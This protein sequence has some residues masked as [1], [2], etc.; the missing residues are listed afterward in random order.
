MKTKKNSL[1][2]LFAICFF[3]LLAFSSNEGRAQVTT[4]SSSGLAATYTSLASAITALNAATIT[5]PVTITLTGDETAPAGGY[6]ITQLSGTATNTITIQGSG[7][8]ITAFSPQVAGQ[9]YDA[10]FKIVGGDWITIQNFTMKENSLNTVATLANNTMTEWGVGLFATSTTNGAQNNTIQNNII[11]L[12]SSTSYQNAI[13]VFSNTASS[14]TNTAQAAASIAGTNS[15]NKIYGNTISGV[16]WGVYFLAPAQTATVFESGNDIGGSSLSTGNNITYGKS[17]T[18][19]DLGYTS[20][21]G[22]TPAGVYF[23]NAVGSSVR[24]NTINSQTGL[25]LTS[26]GIICA[27]GTA[28]AGITYTSNFSNNTITITN[29]FT[30]AVSGIVFGSGLA[31]GTIVGSNNTITINQTATAAVSAAINGIKASYASATNT[32]SSNTIVINQTETTGALSSTTYGIN[33]AGASTTLTANSNNIT[34][35]Q[36]GSG[37]GTITGATYGID[38][39][40][41]ATTINS[42]SNTVLVNQTTGVVNG[43]INSIAGLNATSA[44]TTLNIGSAG[45]G[46]T[47]TLKQEI[48]GSGSYG[49]CSVTYINAASSSATLNIVGN[50]INNTG[51]AQRSTGTTTAISHSGTITSALTVNNNTINS[52]LGTTGPA[53]LY[54]I[55]SNGSTGSI[56][57]YNITNNNITFTNTTSGSTVYGIYNTDGGSTANK[58]LTGNTISISGTAISTNGMTLGYS[59]AYSVSGNTFNLISNSTAATQLA[60]IFFNTTALGAHSVTNNTFAA[61]NLTGM[62]TTSPIVAAITLSMG[63]GVTIYGNIVTNI[64]IGAAG[65]T[66][67]PTIDGILI[68]GGTLTN[69]YQNKIYGISSLCS[70]ATGVVNGIRITAGTTNN[71]NNNLIGGLTATAASNPDAIRG[72]SITS[73][74]AS[75]TNNIYYNTVYLT[76]TGGAN[77]GGSGIYHATNAT[78]TTAALNLRNNIIVNNCTPSGTGLAVAFRRS[79]TSLTNYAATSNNNLFYGSN[80]FTDGTNTDATLAAFQTRVGPTRDALSKTENISFASTLGSDANYLHFAAGAINLAG[81]FAAPISGYTTDYDLETRDVSTP[82]IGADEFVQGLAAVPT[83]TSFTPATLC[84]AGGQTVTITGTNFTGITSVKFNGTNAASYTVISTTSITAITP[85]SITAGAITVTNSGGTATSATNYTVV[86][87]PTIGVTTSLAICSDQS[88][89]PLTANGG[90]TYAWTPATGLSATV[91]TTVTANPSTNTTYTVTGTDGNGCFSTASTTVTVN[92]APSAVT[93]TQSPAAVCAGSVATL[94]ASGGTIA[95][96]VTGTIGT[97]ISLTSATTQPTAFCNR[98][99]NYWSQTIYTAAELTAAGFSAGNINSLAYNITSLGDAATNANLNIKIGATS[100]STFPS[101]TYLSTTGFTSVYGPS[102]YTHTATGWQT[103]T[104]NTPYVW[105]GTS[106]IVIN[107]T[108]DGANLTNNSI[109]YYTTTSGNTTICTSSGYTAGVTTTGTTSTQRLDIKFA[110]TGSSNSPI[111]WSPTTNLFS[112]AAATTAYTGGA[113][114]VV[115]A[116]NTTGTAYSASASNGTCST[117]GTITTNI[118]PLPVISASGATICNGGSTTLTASGGTSYVWVPTTSLSA[119]TGNPVTANPTSTT[120]YTITGTSSGCIGTTTATVTVNSPVLITSQPVNQVILDGATATYSLVATGTGL[121]YQW[122]ENTGS[123]FVDISGETSATLSFTGTASMTGYLY[124]CIVSGASPC[125]SVTSSSALLT[126]SSISIT[127][128]PASTAICSNGIATFSIST[129]GGVTS[130]QWQVNTGSGWSDMSGETGTSISV[131]GLTSANTGT[132]YQCILNA[133][134][135]TSNTAVLT[136]YDVVAI[137]TQ[138]SNQTTCSN[139]PSIAFSVSATGSG[140]TYQWQV[141]TNAGASWSNIGGATS[142][143]YTISTPGIALN[144]NEYHVIVS[145]SSPCSAVTSNTVT[146]IVI[147][148]STAASSG[149]ICANTA[150][151]LTATPT[152]GSPTLSYSWSGIAASG[153]STPVTGNPASITPTA[154]GTFTYTLTATG[155]TCTLTSTQIVTVNALPNITSATAAPATVCN[156]DAITLT[157]ASLQANIGTAAIGT[158][159]TTASSYDNPFYSLWSNTQEQILVKASEL[160]AAGLVAGNLTSLGM[161][162]TSGTTIMPDF[163]LSLQ[164]TSSNTLTTLASNGWSNVYTNISGLTP[165]IGVNTINFS[166]P[167]YWDGSSNLLLKF[168]WGNSGTTATQSNT[169]KADVTTYVCSINAHNSIGTSGSSICASTTFYSSYS[170][171]PKFIF[172]GQVGTN[173]TASYNWSWNS[174]PAVNTATGTTTASNVGVSAASQSFTVTATNPSSGCSATLTT[175]PITIYPTPSAPVAT[176]TNQCGTQTP[177]CSVIGSGINGNTFQWYLVAS[178]GSP[179][180][181]QTGTSLSNYPVSATTTFYVSETN[182]TCSSSRTAVSTTFTGPPTVNILAGTNPLCS[183]SLT[184]LTASSANSDYTYTWSNSLGSGNSVSVSPATATT[185]SVSAVDNSGG[186]Y[187]GCV[188][189]GTVSVSVNPV[190][191]AVTAAVSASSIC[192]GNA[193]NLTS[194]SISGNNPINYTQGFETFPPTGWTMINAGSGNAWITS[195]SSHSGV[196]AIQ[197]TY[198]VSNAGNAWAISVGHSL[199]AG[200]TYTISY[201]YKV[202]LASYPEKLKLTVGSLATVAGQTTTLLTQA[203]LTNTTYA[204]ATTTY[205]PLTTGIYYFGLNCFSAANM[206]ILYVDDF[207]ITGTGAPANYSW[208]SSPSGFT[209]ALQNPTGVSPAATTQYNVT[210]TNS[211]GCSASNSVSVVVN[212]NIPV[213]VSIATTATIICA[214]SSVTFTATPV[215]EG[216]SPSYQWDINGSDVAGAP[217]S[218]IFTTSGLT[219]GQTV[220]CIMT[221]N[222]GSC[223]TNS[224]AMSNIFTITVNPSIPASVAV[225]ATS[226]SICPG[227]SITFTASPTNGGTTPTY[228]WYQNAVTVGS[229]SNTFASSALANSDNITCVMTSNASGCLTNSPATSNPVSITLNT[230]SPVSTL[231]SGDM[232]WNGNTSNDWT[233]TSNW[234]DY[235]NSY[236]IATALP[237]SISNVIIP[238][239]GTCVSSQPS[240]SNGDFNNIVIEPNA[241]LNMNLGTINVLGNWTNSG[242]FIPN[243]SSV[244]F[245]GNTP[246]TIHSNG[247]SFNNVTF[248]NNSVGNSG[249]IINDQMTIDGTGTFTNGIV[250][251]SGTGTLSFTNIATCPNGGSANS[252]VNTSGANFVSKTGTDGFIFPVGEIDSLGNKVWAPIEIAAPALSST[253]TA[254]YNFV[255]SPNNFDPDF[256]CNLND[257]ANT[258]G[259]EYWNLTTD[260]ATPDVTLYWKD[261]IRSNINSIIDLLVAHFEN[262]GGTDKWVSKGGFVSG[263]LFSGSIA[264]TIPFTNYSPVTFGSLSSPLPISLTKFTASCIGNGVEINWTTA[265]ETNNNYF[266]IERSIDAQS[267]EAIKTI[268]GAG[269]SN[270]SINYLFT[271]KNSIN[272]KSY[273]RLKQTDFDGKFT[274][275]SVVNVNCQSESSAEII[276]YPNPAEYNVYFHILLPKKENVILNVYDVMGQKVFSTEISVDGMQNYQLD[277]DGFANGNYRYMV[278]SKNQIFNGQFVKENNRK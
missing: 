107:I 75:S 194:S 101:T 48:S 206:D 158:G 198:N 257:L 55:Y 196:R 170:N 270:H 62:L 212:P 148:V 211:F 153:A 215:N 183:G 263:N 36:T 118:N 252:F 22:T 34:I 149:S 31:T 213:S 147:G 70:G 262:C 1:K 122:Q 23:R 251:Y 17:N 135:V 47:I 28:P 175:S 162:V 207:S 54:G 182:G 38:Y 271:D 105:N 30:T 141:S 173:Q 20:F 259:K 64:A 46:N 136:V 164:A 3:L 242:A 234:Y 165:V 156:G 233:N 78:A 40:A 218:N 32:C 14:A 208:T 172:G 33:I 117:S 195:T 191:T 155:G 202:A 152:A 5:A 168:C 138:P 115:Y 204:Q 68:S 231:T 190:P 277:L 12:S 145:G 91:G 35:N 179:I 226:T 8:T 209:S 250:N 73:T 127:S 51:S 41:A 56:P 49:T 197:Y 102:T 9:K 139:A 92:P 273:Y 80:I 137:G 19:G 84:F 200:I 83:I 42:L 4:N 98:W 57:T 120:T 37:T 186:S 214:G 39:S 151:V 272:G 67:S 275:S 85:P 220:N 254:D 111:T 269:N 246:Q 276:A 154:A 108:M 90:S 79:N 11:T 16:A 123:G 160:S 15:F 187:N 249:I 244:Y 142:S 267:W 45:N 264:S 18:A 236:S 140:L 258:S 87:A 95:S 205:T 159:S 245:N 224:P 52:N 221:S 143:T 59:N 24:F 268:N 65:S 13:G 265:S 217:N 201:W 60:G 116:V 100:I 256:M 106:N 104:F 278:I 166:T 129:S 44:A 131:S 99:G 132:Q 223:L 124:Q 171:R 235:S 112:D 210:A 243:S 134:A 7:S 53:S 6:S 130:Y 109:S 216:T 86:T 169:V 241:T 144:G 219:N 21:S 247:G 163:T 150:V 180:S 248:N 266:T 27:N 61:L 260:A 58:I 66:G 174:T 110:A 261:G 121:S 89:S 88:G 77:F 274:Y 74:T 71:I 96:A 82:D 126:I 125:S 229:N 188:N 2:A 203:S 161:E 26:A 113:S 189:S 114:N 238:K 227:D 81:G 177:T 199:T 133:G 240:I 239:N 103:I 178:G 93:I 192:N 29:T 232:I 43:I 181:G 255:A 25:T 184:S 193:V 50:T 146:L 97:N 72:I 225:A 176:N 253:I 237:T 10:I 119:T 69:V 63:N 230:P 128:Q 157:A 167:F 76:G 228:Q 94:T 185:Y 222:A